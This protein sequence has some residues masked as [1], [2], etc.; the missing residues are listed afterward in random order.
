[1]KSTV[2]EKLTSRAD[3]LKSNNDPQKSGPLSEKKSKHAV[4]SDILDNDF[5][6]NV[7]MLNLKEETKAAALQIRTTITVQLR[8]K[9]LAL[10][11][12]SIVK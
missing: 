3:V 11:L 2:E 7:M 1:M 8:R 12:T 4:K 5:A 10:A 6:V 9:F